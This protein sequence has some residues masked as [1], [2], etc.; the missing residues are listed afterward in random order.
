MRL[1]PSSRFQKFF[2]P[3]WECVGLFPHIRP[4]SWECECDSQV[5][6]QPTPFHAPCLGHEPRAKVVT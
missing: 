1:D 6:F 3:T 5:A 4:H 2:G